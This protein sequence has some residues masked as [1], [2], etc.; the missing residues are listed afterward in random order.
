MAVANSLTPN[1]DNVTFTPQAM[2]PAADGSTDSVIRTSSRVVIVGAVTND[3]N[4][5]ILLPALAD[6]A[7]GHEIKVFCNA[8]GAFEV[9]TPAASGEKINAVDSDGT[10]EY[11]CVDTEITVFTKVSTADGWQAVDLAP[12]GGVGSATTPD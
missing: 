11:A 6:V 4:D 1:F 7:I 5:W 9:R 12:G 2:T 3:T 8:G 10:Q